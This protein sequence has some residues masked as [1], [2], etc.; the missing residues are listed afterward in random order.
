MGPV[1]ARCSHTL[2]SLFSSCVLPTEELNLP[3]GDSQLQFQMR[4]FKRSDLVFTCVCCVPFIFCSSCCR[5][6]TERGLNRKH[7]IEGKLLFSP[8]PPPVASSF[9]SPRHACSCRFPLISLPY[10]PVVPPPP[11]LCDCAPVRMQKLLLRKSQICPTQ[12]SCLLRGSSVL[13]DVMKPC[14]NT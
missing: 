12:M 6:E 1:S 13:C 7:I 3:L 11:P 4:P 10:A 2:H 8:L 14:L 5:A 9:T